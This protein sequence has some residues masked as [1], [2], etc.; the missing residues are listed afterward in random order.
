MY[1]VPRV[2]LKRPYVHPRMRG[3]LETFVEFL[4][5]Y[6]LN[7]I[8]KLFYDRLEKATI[9]CAEIVDKAHCDQSF[10]MIELCW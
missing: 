2:I 3:F 9:N 5:A 10:Y 4:D 1:V 6:E 7:G 8:Q